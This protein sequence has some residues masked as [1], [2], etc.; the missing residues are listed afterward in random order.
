MHTIPYEKPSESDKVGLRTSKFK[1][2]R[3]RKNSLRTVHL[4]DLINDPKEI[5][6]IAQNN[7]K[8]V[9]E[10][11]LI[12]SKYYSKN[13]IKVEEKL[14]GKQRSLALKTLKEMGYD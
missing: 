7:P 11:E 2:Y 8:I 14:V 5:N 10:M 3:S 9:D 12:L 4:F 6:N 13:E 1:Y